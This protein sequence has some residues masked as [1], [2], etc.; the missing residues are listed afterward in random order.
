M[1]GTLRMTASGMHRSTD[2][3][4]KVR[5]VG[6]EVVS[7]TDEEIVIALPTDRPLLFTRLGPDDLRRDGCFV[8]FYSDLVA[9][10]HSQI[11]FERGVFW[12]HDLSSSGGSYVN[13]VRLSRARQL[14]DG[15]VIEVGAYQLRF[16]RRQTP[17]DMSS[18]DAG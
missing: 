17:T 13:G 16:E 11:V 4:S 3:A 9:R 14:H 10:R 18:K 7:R 6:P 1:I 5:V 2:L 8:S 15:D 12:L